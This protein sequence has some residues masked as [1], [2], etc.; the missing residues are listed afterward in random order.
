MLER[1]VKVVYKFQ[2]STPNHLRVRLDCASFAECIKSLP[3]AHFTPLPIQW[4]VIVVKCG[5]EQI[6]FAIALH[7]PHLD[8]R[9]SMRWLGEQSLWRD[10]LFLRSRLFIVSWGLK[11]VSFLFNKLFRKMSKNQRR[12]LS[13]EEVRF[14]VF[15]EENI[16]SISLPSLKLVCLVSSTSTSNFSQYIYRFLLNDDRCDTL[17]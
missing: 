13:N 16:D 8:L 10:S 3:T 2:L 4:T 7:F 14:K 5:I 6:N 11:K 9:S 17:T 15:T 1:R 12:A